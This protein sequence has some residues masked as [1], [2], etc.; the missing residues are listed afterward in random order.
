MSRIQGKT[1]TDSIRVYA[2][3]DVCKASLDLHVLEADTV[4]NGGLSH[5]FANTEAGIRS[6]ISRL[7]ARLAGQPCRVA[8]EPTGRFH[9]AAWKALDAAGHDVVVLNPF[10]ARRFAEAMGLLAKTDAI[11]AYALARAAAC[12]ELASS[13]PPSETHLRIKELQ[14]ARSSIT[15]T[16]AA[17]KNRRGAA[18]DALVKRLL[19]EQVALTEAHITELDA[20][21]ARL[22]EADTALARRRDILASVPGLGPVCVTALIAE[23]P[24][25]GTASDKQIAALLGVAPFNRDSG[26]WR[27]QRKIKGGRAHLRRTLYMAAVTAARFNPPLSAFCKRLRAAG[28]PAKVALTATLRKLI[29]LANALIRDDRLWTPQKP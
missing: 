10:R 12:L 6:M 22:I 16:L 8:I 23:L 5:R 4:G 27:G 28:K 24:E 17:T 3:I 21:L 15:R 9:L 20:E 19:S 29:I 7:D 2:G 25:L 26:Q 1:F 11:D 18:C 13:S 14:A